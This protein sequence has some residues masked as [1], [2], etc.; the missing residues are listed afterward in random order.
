MEGVGWPMLLRT[1]KGMN[2]HNTKRMKE[3][4]REAEGDKK[5]GVEFTGEGEAGRKDK[6]WLAEA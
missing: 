4:R 1:P 2:R 6:K 5:S 3:V